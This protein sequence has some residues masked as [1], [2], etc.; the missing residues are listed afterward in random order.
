MDGSKQREWEDDMTQ[1]SFFHI[2]RERLSGPRAWAD[3]RLLTTKMIEAVLML[4][5]FFHFGVGQSFPSSSKPYHSYPGLSQSIRSGIV[6]GPS[7]W[8]CISL[9]SAQMFRELVTC[10]INSINS[11]IGIQ[12]IP[13]PP[14]LL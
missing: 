4:R 12:T 7:V 13:P 11:L 9:Y 8:P 1:R 14:R 2:G 3:L 6:Q 5:L 10:E